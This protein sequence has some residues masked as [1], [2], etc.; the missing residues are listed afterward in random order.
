M[1]F[2]G[3][4]EADGREGG[5]SDPVA[6]LADGVGRRGALHSV[7]NLS[8][9]RQKPINLSLTFAR[10]H[11]PLSSP[12]LG[13]AAGRSALLIRKAASP[14]TAAVV[15]GVL[16]RVLRGSPCVAGL[17]APGTRT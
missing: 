4:R 2:G 7:E 11:Q 6:H 3:A 12:L 17:D 14:Q 5:S 1:N 13:L 8:D 9:P 16:E 10:S 15:F